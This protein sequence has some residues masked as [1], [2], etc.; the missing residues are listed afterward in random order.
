[1]FNPYAIAF[2]CVAA[3]AVAGADYVVQSRAHGAHPGAYPLSDYIGGYSRRVEAALARIDTARRQSQ[4]AR[5]HLPETLP[6]WE[7]R[8]WTRDE[9]KDAARTA[10]MTL[11][12]QRAFKDRVTRA[13]RAADAQ[14]FE[15]VRGDDRVR[16]SAVFD[17][18]ADKQARAE[19]FVA[20]GV[21]VDGARLSGYDIIA[22]V[23]F[24]RLHPPA[25][26]RDA[27]RD[28]PVMLQAYI[29][30]SVAIGVHAEAA[31]AGLPGILAAIDYDGLNAMRDT[32]LPGI[33]SAAAELPDARRRARLEAAVTA[34]QG[35][36]GPSVPEGVAAR[37]GAGGGPPGDGR[38]PARSGAA[39][40][41]AR[42]AAGQDGA[43][44]TAPTRLQ[45]SGGRS[46]LGGSG[47]RLCD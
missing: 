47:S 2:A 7:R 45:L 19:A 21:S 9:S 42:A 26:R 41:G 15:Y 35:A 23:P 11:L 5:T 13:R 39:G 22:G 24:F 16:L 37:P 33:G 43:A 18:D 17:P 14:V 44:E 32:P 31:Y 46:C 10:G 27:G 30:D 25:H 8:A 1:M 3:V 40:G 28:G 34:L 4:P 20:P 38:A 6:G 12:E 29:G 36:R